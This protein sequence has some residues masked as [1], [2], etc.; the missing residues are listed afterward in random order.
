[1]SVDLLPGFTPATND[2]FTVV[3]AGTRS[4]TFSTFAFPSNRVSLTLSNSPNSVVLRATEVFAVP[5]PVLLNPE[6][7][8]QAVKLTWTATSNVA[9]R[10]EYLPSLGSTNWSAIAGDVTTLSNTASKLDPLTI[11]NRFYR[12]R[13]LP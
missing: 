7:T 5:A 1:L 4:G 3:S 10:L 6:L 2:T 13:V 12:V 9:Y 11:S 8:G